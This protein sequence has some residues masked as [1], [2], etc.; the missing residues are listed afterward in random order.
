MTWTQPEDRRYSAPHPFGDVPLLRFRDRRTTRTTDLIPEEN[1]S[2]H[3]NRM[4]RPSD[5]V[6]TI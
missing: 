1:Y 5:L 6:C 3:L 2:A 4:Y